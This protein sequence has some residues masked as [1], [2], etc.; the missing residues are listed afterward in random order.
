VPLFVLLSLFR[1]LGDGYAVTQQTV[2]VDDFLT[3]L[4]PAV[5][6]IGI[7]LHLHNHPSAASPL[8]NFLW[9]L[10]ALPLGGAIAISYCNG[11][12]S[13]N[14]LTLLQSI[15]RGFARWPNAL[16]VFWTFVLIM[17]V[18]FV[19]VVLLFGVGLG[20]VMAFAASYSHVAY[21][22]GLTLAI[23]IMFPGLML[24]YVPA[25]LSFCA[26]VV[27]E[28]PLRKALGFG[29]KSQFRR[30]RFLASLGAGLAIGFVTGF[31]NY[32][33]T[34]GGFFVFGL[35]G[36][37]ALDVVVQVVGGVVVSGF[38]ANA[39]LLLYREY[40]RREAVMTVGGSPVE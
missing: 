38:L 32:A 29:L 15:G 21:V 7:K 12:Y 24:C 14:H 9:V 17:L 20:L 28:Q 3:R 10:L 25:L 33:T 16:L 31:L 35:T 11:L 13:G 39:A 6:L 8:P 18:L 23:L 27:D 1:F 40:Q 22:A 19:L 34:F 26:V 4:A 37:D 2:G 30:G 5:H 36:S